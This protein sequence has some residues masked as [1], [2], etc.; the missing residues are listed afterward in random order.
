[1]I[2]TDIARDPLWA[3]YRIVRSKPA[4]ERAGRHRSCPARGDVLGTFAMYHRQPFTPSSM[5]L[6]LIELASNLARI[7]I[8]RDAAERD[9]ER[10]WDAKRFADRYRMVLQAT[11][12]VVWEW[13][14][15]IGVVHWNE[16]IGHVRLRRA[17]AE[18]TLDWWT[19]AHPSG[20]GRTRPRTSR[21][22]AVGSGKPHLGGG[23]SLSA[24][25]RD[26]RGCCRPRPH[27]PRRNGQGTCESSA[28]CRTSRDESSDE[29]EVEQM[30]ERLQ[31]ASIAR[32]GRHVAPGREDGV[33]LADPSL[34]RL[35]GREEEETVQRFGDAI[36]VVHPEDRARVAQALDESIT[37][38]DPYAKRSPGGARRR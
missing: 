24:E 8:E 29:Q 27:R 5:H 25:E 10:I 23:I 26:V 30:A 17:E 34:N 28:H 4:S 12:D 11:G 2:V 13:D 14:L 35:F 21:E 9:R 18:R 7:A 37:T 38:G 3:D 1:M 16:R 33:F 36:R 20:G 22:L 31:S 32:R 15:E 19:R 6:S